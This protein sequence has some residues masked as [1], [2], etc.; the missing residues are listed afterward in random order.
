M[1]CTMGFCRL[2][3]SRAETVTR[4][5]DASGAPSRPPAL[6]AFTEDEREQ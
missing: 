1:D 2:P 6:V 4:L 5:I 3:R